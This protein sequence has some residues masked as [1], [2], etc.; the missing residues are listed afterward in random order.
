[1][2]CPNCKTESFVT[3]DYEEV[4]IDKCKTCHG[5]WLDHSKISEIVSNRV[6]EFSPSET[7]LT[8][9]MAFAGIPEFEAQNIR[10]CPICQSELKCLNYAV[11]AGVILDTCPSDHGIWFDNHELEKIQEFREYW[12]DQAYGNEESFLRM[13][14]ERE[15][16]EHEKKAIS[17]SILFNLASFL[18]D[19]FFK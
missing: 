8:L 5:V 2:I 4:T 12:A 13:L 7:K 9:S 16:S 18:G 10:H 3:T 14:K 19:K 11:D 1:M 6:K 15:K 17:K